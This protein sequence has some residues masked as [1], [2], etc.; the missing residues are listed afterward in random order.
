[1]FAT[2]SLVAPWIP[3]ICMSW[4]AHRQWLMEFQ[5]SQKTFSQA[6]VYI[7]VAI[8]NSFWRLLYIFVSCCY[9]QRPS[10]NIHWVGWWEILQVTMELILFFVIKYRCFLHMFPLTNTWKHG[11]N[12]ILHWFG[13]QNSQ[14]LGSSIFATERCQ[15]Q[16]QWHLHGT[17]WDEAQQC[18]AMFNLCVQK[19]CHHQIVGKS[20]AKS[21]K[22][23]DHIFTCQ[24]SMAM[25]DWHFEV[26]GC[27]E[28]KTSDGHSHSGQHVTTS[29]PRNREQCLGTVICNPIREQFWLAPMFTTIAQRQ[30]DTHIMW[31]QKPWRECERIMIEIPCISCI[32]Q[33]VVEQ[34]SA[35]KTPGRATNSSRKSNR[36][37]PDGWVWFGALGFRSFGLLW[38][39]T[40]CDTLQ[41]LV[42]VEAPKM[43]G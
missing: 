27:G 24:H 25:F 29:C 34:R 28:W 18:S 20:C 12:Q 3:V 14:G 32:T 11:Q 40:H 41:F 7:R 8:S 21:V 6:L 19:M 39:D 33:S 26:A 23:W 15:S 13:A 43:A 5:N 36:S 9:R 1:M 42:Q 2:Y 35:M 4:R 30:L 17:G 22:T 38:V 31:E 37:F 10:R 16:C